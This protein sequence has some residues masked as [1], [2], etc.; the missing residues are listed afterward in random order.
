MNNRLKYP[1]NSIV[2]NGKIK[3]FGGVILK[4]KTKRIVC[5]NTLDLRIQNS[6]EKMSPFIRKNLFEY[7]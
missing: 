2:L 3:S 5:K 4:D 7:K 1:R 6:F